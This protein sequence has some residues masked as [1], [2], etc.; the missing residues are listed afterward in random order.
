MQI[1]YSD[2]IIT[3]TVGTRIL[4]PCVA[5]NDLGIAMQPSLKL[6]M[7]CTQIAAK[8]KARAKLILKVSL[9][10]DAQSLTRTFT[11]FAHPIFEYVTPVWR[12]YFKTDINI[13]ENVQHS[14]T[15][16]LFLPM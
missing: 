4:L 12:P 8:A 1:G 9:S 14:F 16:T 11:T 5:T 2:N 10:H 6:E 15:R 7:H 3:Y 13:I